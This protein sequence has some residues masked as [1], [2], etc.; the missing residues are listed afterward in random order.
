MVKL[1]DSHMRGEIVDGDTLF[2]LSVK[3][4]NEEMDSIVDNEM[5]VSLHLD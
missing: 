2:I 4:D 3:D 1:I 5:E